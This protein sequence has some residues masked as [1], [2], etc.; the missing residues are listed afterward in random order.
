[1]SRFLTEEQLE[2][3]RATRTF[4]RRTSGRVPGVAIA[5][6]PQMVFAPVMP[7]AE[8]AGRG[9][10]VTAPEQSRYASGAADRPT[11]PTRLGRALRPTR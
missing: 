7:Q 4:A 3:Q 9:R 10:A 2:I 6:I 11:R 1:M 5:G 8:H